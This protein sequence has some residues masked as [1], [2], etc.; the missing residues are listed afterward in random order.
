MRAHTITTTTTKLALLLSL[1]ALG[2]LGLVACGGGDND[3]TT[4]ASE[5]EATGDEPVAENKSCGY[6]G[7]WKLAVVGG[8]PCDVAR[9]VL[10]ES[11]FHERTPGFWKC[12]G[13][14]GNPVCLNEAHGLNETVGDPG[15][16]LI[17]GWCC[18]V[19]Q[20]RAYIHAADQLAVGVPDPAVLKALAHH[21]ELLR[22]SATEAK[23]SSHSTPEA[24]LSP[25]QVQE[26]KR[27]ANRWASLFA[28]RASTAW[29]RAGAS[30]WSA[31]RRNRYIGQPM[32]QRLDC[33]MIENCTP[34]S[35][36]Y[37]K[38]FADA[39]VEDI[40]PVRTVRVRW[41]DSPLHYAAVRFSN[42][43]VVVFNGG[44]EGFTCAGGGSAC[45]W[46]I[47]EPD[48]N[49]RFLEAAAPRE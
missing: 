30:P 36:A 3:Q 20:R 13:G 40:K 7:R 31:C 23:L 21:V 12:Y 34:V 43:E 29:E 47:A 48:H 28:V 25:E 4:A 27:E 5:T 41:T 35:A 1:L 8:V 37:Q 26:L 2:A 39:R 18:G 32:C 46:S 38:S 42:G 6:L 16:E 9:G 24:K 10:R 19:P 17:V 15:S 33:E 22:A 49:R 44:A 14:E 11:I 45:T